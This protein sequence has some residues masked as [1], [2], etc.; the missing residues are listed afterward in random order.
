M[1]LSK[2]KEGLLNFEEKKTGG[3]LIEF[4]SYFISLSNTDD[5]LRNIINVVTDLYKDP[6]NTY[7]PCFKMIEI[8]YQELKG[9]DI[10]PLLR[11]AREKAL[12]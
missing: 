1:L 10:E 9:E 8:A 5:G 3:E 7:I 11:E 2:I 12:P 6:P 4:R